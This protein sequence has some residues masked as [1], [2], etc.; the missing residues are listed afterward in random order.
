M[1]SAAAWLRDS[2]VI[3]GNMT[4]KDDICDQGCNKLRIFLVILGLYLFLLFILNVTN[5]IITVRSVDL[6][7][8]SCVWIAL[9]NHLGMLDRTV[10]D[11]LG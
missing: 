5:V 6:Q 9:V 10:D 1:K 11:R 3:L 8:S 4:A 7:C 2:R